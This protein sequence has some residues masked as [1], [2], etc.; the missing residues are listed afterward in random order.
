MPVRPLHLFPDPLLSQPCHPVLDFGPNL[1][2]L[3]QDLIDTLESTPGVGLA[4]PQIGTLTRIS[5]IDLT[6]H[7]GKQKVPLHRALRYFI[8]NPKIVRAAGN[9]VPREGCLSVP[10][11]LGN[12]RR[13]NEVVVKSLD[14]EGNERLLEAQG[15][16]A[17]ALQH[18]IDHLDGTL[19]LDR[20]LDIKSDIFRRKST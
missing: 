13:F 6:R 18:E 12:V 4:A 1:K 8:V 11:L 3:A 7:K 5:Y 17:L 16:E 2:A 14:L 19:F 20:I 10:D 9:Q 15:F